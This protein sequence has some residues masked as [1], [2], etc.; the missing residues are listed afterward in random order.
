MSP[1]VGSD[2]VIEAHASGHY[3]ATADQWADVDN[4]LRKR[5]VTVAGFT[6]RR[7]DTTPPWTAYTP[8][9]D[10]DYAAECTITHDPRVW[11]VVAQG[12]EQATAM[13][14]RRGNGKTRPGVWVTWQVLEHA[15]GWRYHRLVAHLPSSV[16]AGKRW[17]KGRRALVWA[18]AAVGIRQL[19][20]RLRKDHGRGEC[21]LSNDLNVDVTSPIWQRR[22]Q[23]ALGGRHMR[24]IAPRRGTHGN[25]GID[26]LVST[27]RG[28]LVVLPA[29]N[30]LDHRP[31]LAV[32]RRRKRSARLHSQRLDQMASPE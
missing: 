2:L 16:Q 13:T 22:A 6:E 30:G 12:A 32:L 25:R 14:F 5:H 4:L 1:H 15:D 26:A 24:L 20:P 29:Q 23:R 21:T 10:V 8:Y 3:A 7:I 31:V 9:R 17:R 18:S 11:T 28:N 19:R 27:M